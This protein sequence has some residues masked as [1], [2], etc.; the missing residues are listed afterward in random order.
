MD[1]LVNG[2]REQNRPVPDGAIIVK[3]MFDP[4]AIQWRG[5][6]DAGLEKKL[7]QM[8]KQL[9]WTV[10]VKD[11]KGSFDGWFWSGPSN[12]GGG[13]IP[14]DHPGRYP[15]DIPDSDFGAYCIRC[16]AS[17][18][19]DHTFSALANIEG[20]PGD[21]LIFRVDDSWRNASSKGATSKVE[22]LADSLQQAYQDHQRLAGTTMLDQQ[23][24]TSQAN[25]LFLKT[26]PSLSRVSY[27][28]VEKLP[29]ETYDRVVSPHG[30]PEQYLSSDQCLSCHSG[31]TP[32]ATY[33]PIM[34][35]TNPDTGFEMNVSPYG[36]WRWSPMGLAGRDPVFYA[37]LESEL[38]YIETIEPPARRK[39]IRKTVE[40]LC[41]SCH[42]AMGQRQYAIDHPVHPDFRLEYMFATP[43]RNPKMAK[44]GGLG[45]DGIS[46]GV[47]HHIARAEDTSLEYFLTRNS[48]GHFE[49]GPSDELF[50]PLE[51]VAEIPMEHG[52]GI[53]PKY[54][55]Y[56]QSSRLC[57]TCHLID[58]P[59]VDSP[60][61]NVS[62]IEQATYLEWLNSDFQNEYPPLSEEAQSCQEC[63]MPS[64]YHNNGIDEKQIRT[65]I[66][67]VQDTTYP[68][69]EYLSPL[70]ELDVRYRET[71]FVRHELVGLNVFLLEIS[72]S[73]TI[74]LAYARKTI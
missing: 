36:E 12:E 32:G 23:P 3:E 45:R 16:H 11:S 34:L 43:E 55:E 48:T 21:P 60:E 14:V 71:G 46:C 31:F 19:D 61:P 47:C 18:T 44:Y 2:G 40:N 66:A 25:S 37:Q 62:H 24:L 26:F 70:E 28:E 54:D 51:D 35:L 7:K 15:F 38:A 8:G 42:G 58:I 6:D 30:G 10:M 13:N 63:H 52:L 65:R 9:Q 4:P 57:G 53:T 56:I 41:L 27:E 50:G 22:S 72:P 5:L 59:V 1:W 69:V 17:A 29:P 20:F 73:S 49:N 74:S 39:Q 64:G 33:G 68:Q 67:T